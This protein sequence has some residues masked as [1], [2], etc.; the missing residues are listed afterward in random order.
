ML[1]RSWRL[2]A[3][4]SQ[5]GMILTWLQCLSAN[6]TAKWAHLMRKRF[7]LIS[8]RYF[9]YIIVQMKRGDTLGS[10]EYVILLALM[11]LNGVGH[12]T[13]VRQE[14]ERCTGRDISIGAIYATL[15]RLEQKGYVSSCIG[16]ST[17]MR[18]GRA[19]RLFRVEAEGKRALQISSQTIRDLT[20]G[21]RKRWQAI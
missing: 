20:R 11:R 13:L 18:G 14:I 6:C 8:C 12:G 7:L 2:M 3:I 15:E 21:L 19:K 5:G 17:A 10:L 1:A 16:E 4:T 9:F